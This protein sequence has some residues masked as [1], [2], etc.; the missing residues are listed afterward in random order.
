MHL[1]A[2]GTSGRGVPVEVSQRIV[3]PGVNRGND[4]IHNEEDG[5]D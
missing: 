4:S 1:Q 3:K 5:E 2:S